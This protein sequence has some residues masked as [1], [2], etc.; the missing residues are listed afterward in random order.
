MLTLSLLSC[1][2]NRV[3]DGSKRAYNPLVGAWEMETVN[4]ITADTTYSIPDAQPGL[5]LFIK[6]NYSI[7]WT[8]IET[9][10]VPFKNLS[11]PTNEEIIAG[12]Q[13]VVFN[14]GSY[15]FTD[16]TLTSIAFIAKVPGFEGGKQ[17]YRYKIEKDRLYLTMFDETYP[18][19]NKPKW[20]GRY[21][22]E[23]IMKK[24]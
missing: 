23:F 24:K 17:F 13:S 19:G 12:F 8:P 6:K 3:V 15:V 10:R 5:F 14:A 21:V 1:N 18:D 9:L 16:S 4:W 2:A 11:K 20:I 22:T 7:Q